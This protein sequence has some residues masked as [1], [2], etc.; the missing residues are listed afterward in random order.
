MRDRKHEAVLVGM[1]VERSILSKQIEA[2]EG[3]AASRCSDYDPEN[4]HWKK[5]DNL[6]LDQDKL[7]LKIRTFNDNTL[8]D[9]SEENVTLSSFLNEPSPKKES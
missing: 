8:V 3:R 2:V 6:L 7:L 4:A 5:V 1:S 9:K